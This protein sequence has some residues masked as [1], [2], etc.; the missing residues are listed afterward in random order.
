MN[1]RS[2]M[3]D[4]GINYL[5]IN[6]TN[7]FLVEYN[8]LSQ[9]S[10]YKLTGFT[11][12]TGEALV[13]PETIYLFVDGR[14]HMQADMEV[15][16]NLVT[17]I[18]LQ[19]GE[20]I[21]EEIINKIPLNEILGVFSKKNSQKKIDELSLKRKLKLFERDPFDE[22]MIYSSEGDIQIDTKYTGINSEDKILRIS[23]NLSN[24]EA[25]YITD[26][27]EVSYLFNMRN[28]TRQPYSA[29]ILAKAMIMKDNAILFS[30]EKLKNLDDFLRNIKHDVYVDKST[31][32]AYEYNLLGNRAIE[33]KTNIV[34]L[35]KAQKNKF[36][37]E[38]LKSAFTRTDNAVFAI[39]DYIMSNDN[40]SEFDI[41]VQLAKE[42]KKQGAL[43]LS[44]ASIVA[45]DKNSAL[46]H[47][48]KCSKDEIIKDGSLILI[49]CGG[50]FEGGLATDITRVFVKG[51]PLELHKKIYT[52]VLKAF[53]AGYN[54]L[55]THTQRPVTGYDIDK[56]VRNYF[57][58]RD[59]EGFVFNHGLGH[60]IG[61]N[62]HENPP[63]LS[64]N[65]IAKAP[66][67]E[68]ECFTIEP[69]LYKQEYFGIRLENSCYYKDGNIH[70][71]VKMPY[72]KKLINY[73]MLNDIEQEWLKEFEVI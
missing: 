50:Y 6:S 3:Q 19:T 14:Y 20:N 13:T 8:M 61:V 34:K 9:N 27:D 64:M 54:Y 67:I 42:F 11:G 7:E 70:S 44:F 52:N 48:S 21:I 62:V 22:N 46:A 69:G 58:N 38:H 63:N 12:S 41:A 60:G 65:E 49:D 43:G 72:E 53:L 66:F 40:L 73:D 36:E 15:D 16:H 1:I 5:L 18:K 24:D 35:A 31:I 45:K 39:R 33:Q 71:F 25:I 47:Y 37:I 28:F 51:E 2:F 55:K 17:V 10:R 26:P 23:S 59:L 29:K 68:G 32:N 57:N 56:H 30:G 4:N